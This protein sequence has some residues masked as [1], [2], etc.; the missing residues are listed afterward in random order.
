MLVRYERFSRIVVRCLSIVYV[1]KMI[2][3]VCEMFSAFHEM[4]SEFDIE[5]KKVF[6]NGF[7]K[8]AHYFDKDDDGIIQGSEL[9][10]LKFWVDDGDAVTEDGELQSLA[11]HGIHS[12]T[13]PK[14]GEL[15]SSAIVS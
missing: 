11:E 6:E 12:I 3:D 4:M 8:L 14:K 7:D 2:L 13:I 9:D 15:T 10:G 1:C 5:G